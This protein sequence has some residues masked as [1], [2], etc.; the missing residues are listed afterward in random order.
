MS[1]HR[2]TKLDREGERR[3]EQ[4]MRNIRIKRALEIQVAA[5]KRKQRELAGQ[6]GYTASPAQLDEKRGRQ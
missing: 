2:K 5:D 4:R 3:M 6:V 1:K